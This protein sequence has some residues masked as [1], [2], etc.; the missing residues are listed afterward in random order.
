MRSPS[1]S[2]AYPWN[3]VFLANRVDKQTDARTFVSFA[4]EYWLPARYLEGGH[5]KIEKPQAL[6]QKIWNAN[7]IQ[8]ALFA[9]MLIVAAA[10]YSQRDRLVRRADRK[11]K[12]WVRGPQ[13]A[14]WVI[15]VVLVGFGL[16]AQPSITQVLTWFHSLI[17]QWN[18]E[19][20]LSD[21]FIFIFWWFTIITLLI[22]G[23]G[24]FCGWLCPFGSL[25]ELL[26]RAAGAI[27]LARFQFKLPQPVHDKLKWLKYVI[28]F[29][30]L[31]VSFLSMST[32]EK[33]AEVE[34]F[35]TTFLVGVLHRAWPYGLYVAVLLGLSIFIERPFCKYLCP[36]GAGLAIPTT[37][38]LFGLK[39]KQECQTCA[40][41]A[42]G[43]GSQSID[44]QGRID[45]RECMLCLD[46]MILYYDASACPPL[47]QERKRRTKAG[48]PLTAI[49][50]DG[51]YTPS[52]RRPIPHTLAD[53]GSATEATAGKKS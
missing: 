35:K 6:W 33:L 18:W 47:S 17:F 50:S 42:V 23:R 46:C 8:I 12:L 15:G 44:A 49:G 41:C 25:S 21:P 20:F 7:R 10:T 5:P 43:C 14:L 32:A 9:L 3:L 2:A 28:F 40:A 30:L 45:Q 38:R 39:R 29:G 37:F 53:A 11:H 27:G 48:E 51:Y 24:L 1:F 31:G 16:M 19:L 22:W 26:Y 4:R 52:V 34:P 36:L 13:Y